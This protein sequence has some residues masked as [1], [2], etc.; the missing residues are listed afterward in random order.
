M[1]T[2]SDNQIHGS[3]KGPISPL[4][5]GLR[6]F[7]RGL[8]THARHDHPYNL[9]LCSPLIRV[10]HLRVK[11]KIVFCERVIRPDTNADVDRFAGILSDEFNRAKLGAMKL[12]RA[13]VEEGIVR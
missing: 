5:L 13:I 1:A 7:L 12:R 8:V 10:H 6:T 4:L 3:I 2:Y 9:A 11:I